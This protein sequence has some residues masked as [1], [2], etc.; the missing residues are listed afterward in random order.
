M[1]PQLSAALGLVLAVALAQPAAAQ[2]DF[3]KAPKIACTPDSVTRCEAANK[4]TTRPASPG[5]KSEVLVIDFAGKKASVRKG[6][7]TK[8]FADI[9]Q[10]EVS[11][12]VRR[13][14]VTEIGK[15]GQGDKLSMTLSK[16]GKLTLDIG[17]N[18]NKA[19]ATCIAES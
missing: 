5:D 3:M 12:D 7:E 2:T 14:A 4:C 11:G 9:V 10:D 1:K 17:G 8:D 19:E 6:G 15:S 18:G 16:S 13:I